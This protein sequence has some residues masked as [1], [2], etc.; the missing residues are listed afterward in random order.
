MLV[1]GSIIIVIISLA[2]LYLMLSATGLFT[3]I[4]NLFLKQQ[5]RIEEKASEEWIKPQSKQV[6]QQETEENVNE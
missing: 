4:G 6:E 1:I 5:D 3:F 2:V